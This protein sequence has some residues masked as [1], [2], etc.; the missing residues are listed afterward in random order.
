M[1]GLRRKD[2]DRYVRGLYPMLPEGGLYIQAPSGQI[3]LNPM[4]R[5][6]I[7][8]NIKR[9]YLKKRRGEL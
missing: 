8:Q 4:T 9:N 2:I 5:R 3:K 7:R 6:A 1:R